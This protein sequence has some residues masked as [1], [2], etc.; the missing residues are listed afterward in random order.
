MIINGY[1]MA[2]GLMPKQKMEFLRTEELTKY[3]KDLPEYCWDTVKSMDIFRG[4]RCSYCGKIFYD[5]AD[6]CH[7]KDI[8]E[9]EVNEF[10]Q[11]IEELED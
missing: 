9:I 3:D 7:K 11:D 8:E 2:K 1:K 4:Y 6:T 5:I 10:G